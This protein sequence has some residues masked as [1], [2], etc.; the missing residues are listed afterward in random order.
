ML[1]VEF[2]GRKYAPYTAIAI[3]I[4]MKCKK[5]KRND[6]KSYENVM[7]KRRRVGGSGVNRIIVIAVTVVVCVYCLVPSVRCTAYTY[8]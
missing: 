6:E 8:I 5:I 7:Q 1:Y 4:I 2:F 3:I